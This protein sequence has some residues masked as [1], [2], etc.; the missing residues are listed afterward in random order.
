MR[1]REIH[2]AICKFAECQIDEV[3]MLHTIYKIGKSTLLAAE[4]GAIAHYL[5]HLYEAMKQL[6]LSTLEELTDKKVPYDEEF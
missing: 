4:V 6:E 3:E 5:E 2:K 1:N